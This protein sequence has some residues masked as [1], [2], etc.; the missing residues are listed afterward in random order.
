MPG[1]HKFSAS[2]TGIVCC[3]HCGE[4]KAY[5]DTIRVEGKLPPCQEAEDTPAGN[6]LSYSPLSL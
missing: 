4:T 1:R 5:L 2:S 3:E 6:E